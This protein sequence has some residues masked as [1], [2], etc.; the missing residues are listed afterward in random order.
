[1]RVGGH[2]NA[3]LYLAMQTHIDELLQTLHS[4]AKVELASCL[5]TDTRTSI[6]S[7][8]AFGLCLHWSCVDG[9]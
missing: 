8:D 6:K 1:M 2:L 5:L 3:D 4:S 9:F 7:N